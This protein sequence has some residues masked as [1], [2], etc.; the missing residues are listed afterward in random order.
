MENGQAEQ[1]R[2]QALPRK[3]GSER[4]YG[5]EGL[6]LDGTL[7]PQR[8]DVLSLLSLHLRSSVPLLSPELACMGFHSFTPAAGGSRTSGGCH[9]GWSGVQDH[10][11]PAQVCWTASAL[12]PESLVNHMH[13]QLEMNGR[14]LG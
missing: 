3:G 9:A 1:N 10:L 11:V 7:H 6:D 5:A 4:T 14:R 12:N 2:R 13:L 8:A